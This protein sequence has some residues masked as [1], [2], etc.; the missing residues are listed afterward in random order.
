MMV[1]RQ[2]DVLDKRVITM[3]LLPPITLHGW[4]AFLCFP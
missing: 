2:A 3:D 1:I 4:P